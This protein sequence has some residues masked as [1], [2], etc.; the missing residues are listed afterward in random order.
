VLLD[1]IVIAGETVFTLTPPDEAYNTFE[2]EVL[3][4]DTVRVIAAGNSVTELP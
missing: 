2:M 3:G 1:T 4:T